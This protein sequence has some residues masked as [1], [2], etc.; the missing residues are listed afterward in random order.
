MNLLNSF[1]FELPTR[2]EYGA[3][4]ARALADV[5]KSFNASSV[6]MITDKGIMRSGLLER[7]TGP[8]VRRPGPPARGV[9]LLDAV[10]RPVPREDLIRS[11]YL[12][13]C[14]SD[15]TTSPVHSTVRPSFCRIGARSRSC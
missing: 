6:L 12:Q 4:V 7:I 2:I 11:S 3:G 1:S 10:R 15:S 8:L 9:L 13:F 14:R 5:I